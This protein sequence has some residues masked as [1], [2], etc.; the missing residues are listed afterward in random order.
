MRKRNGIPP[1]TAGE[2][3]HAIVGSA[4]TAIVAAAATLVATKGDLDATGVVAFITSTT[5]VIFVVVA[6]F[7]SRSASPS[8]NTRSEPDP[9]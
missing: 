8:R 6:A 2:L 3:Q 1:A 5:T 7:K 4:V 9:G